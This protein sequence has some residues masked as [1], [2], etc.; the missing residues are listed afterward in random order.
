MIDGSL[1]LVAWLVERALGVAAIIGWVLIILTAWAIVLF[2]LGLQDSPLSYL[3]PLGT[4]GYLIY[5]WAAKR[6]PTQTA[7]FEAKMKKLKD[8]SDSL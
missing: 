4:F 8:W 5:T 1:D 3:G 2:P 6:F 7:G